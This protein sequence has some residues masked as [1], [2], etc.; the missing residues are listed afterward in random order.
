[1]NQF[2]NIFM[3]MVMRRLI[4]AGISKGIGALGRRGTGSQPGNGPARG[5]A[6]ATPAAG[7]GAP[8]AHLRRSLRLI[9]RMGRF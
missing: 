5:R 9:R 6:S 3:R 1:M 7:G 4:G 2:V 8:A